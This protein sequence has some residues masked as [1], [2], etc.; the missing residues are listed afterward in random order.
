MYNLQHGNGMGKR[1]QLI[2]IPHF[3]F[4]NHLVVNLLIVA[5]LMSTFYLG[6]L[7]GVLFVEFF[8][9][10]AFLR[11][12]LFGVTTYFPEPLQ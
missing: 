8:S 9:E 7:G 5:F 1:C 11:G 4:L 3:G 12:G 10:E 6:P 2:K